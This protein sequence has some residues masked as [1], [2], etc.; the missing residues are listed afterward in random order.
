MISKLKKKF[1]GYTMCAV[2][3]IFTVIILGIN[4]LNPFRTVSELD[5]ITQIIINSDGH[6]HRNGTKPPSQFSDNRDPYSSRE[7]RFMNNNKEMPFATRFFLVR[8]DGDMN[9]LELDTENIA[10][11]EKEQAE[12]IAAELVKK[13]KDSGWYDSMRY[14]LAETGSGY[15]H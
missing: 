15:S 9:I 8:L 4:G 14:G 10:S 11:I 3:A 1:I 6:L 7:E 13:H 12:I 5:L 2:I